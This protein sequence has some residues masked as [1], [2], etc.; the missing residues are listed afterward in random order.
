[1]ELKCFVC[2]VEHYHASDVIGAFEVPLAVPAILQDHYLRLRAVPGKNLRPQ[3]RVAKE[4]GGLAGARADDG[5]RGHRLLSV[6]RLCSSALRAHAQ[7]SRQ[8]CTN[9]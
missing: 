1:M 3:S 6:L 9:V 4:L 5:R 2:I 8:G 7:I